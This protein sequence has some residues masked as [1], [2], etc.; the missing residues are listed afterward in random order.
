MEGLQQESK[1]DI[2][3][4]FGLMIKPNG[5]VGDYGCMVIFDDGVS[6]N[7]LRYRLII[8][9]IKEVNEYTNFYRIERESSVYINDKEPENFIDILALRVSSVLYPLEVS[10]SYKGTL[11]GIVNF[12]EI[13]ERWKEEKKKIKTKHKGELVNKYIQLTDQS[14]RS[15]DILYQKMIKDWFLNLYFAPLYTSYSED[16]YVEEKIKYPIA[17]KATPVN[18]NVIKKLTDV[19]NSKSNDVMIKMEGE[20]DD[21]RCALDLV[22]ELDTP[23]YRMIN[24]NEKDLKGT[25]NLTYLLNSNNGIVEGIEANFETKFAMPKKVTVKMFLQEVLKSENI[26]IDDDEDNSKPKKGFW[27]KLFNV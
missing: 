24:K 16:L 8:K 11:S 4:D 6:K 5:F 9:H 20:I 18:Y 7:E 10:T 2:L 15:S 25:C 26:D 22:Q 1:V 19:K 14:L 27:A 13:K 17:G 23:Y 21:E 12:E 3:N